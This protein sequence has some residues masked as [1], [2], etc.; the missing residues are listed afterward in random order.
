MSQQRL[1]ELLHAQEHA[2]IA[3]AATA[4]DTKLSAEQIRQMSENLQL[5]LVRTQRS[6]SHLYTVVMARFALSAK[7]ITRHQNIIFTDK[8]KTIN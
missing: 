1:L 8:M 5:Q 6:P 7:Q 2:G 4:A 3:M